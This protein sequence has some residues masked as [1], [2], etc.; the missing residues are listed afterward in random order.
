MAG[1][2]SRSL[3]R[4]RDF[5]IVCSSVGL[6]A[7]GDWVAIVGLGLH[8]EEM[9]GSGFAV[10]ALWICLFGPSVLVAGHAGLLVDRVEATRLLALVSAIGAVAAAV[11]AFVDATA[12]VLALTAALGVVFALMSPAEFSLV[13][14]LA[15]SR[16]QE[17]NGH[18]ETFRYIGFGLGPAVGGLLFA[19]G[20]LELTM[21][22]DAG[23]FAA[24]ALA[25]LALRIRRRP[26]DA[27]A[28]ES[29]RARDGIAFLFRD[30]VL[31]LVM[32]VAF[33]SLLFMSAVWVGE[34]FFVK[35]TLGMG[36]T[37]Y[38]LFMS[39]WTVGMA[40][41][42]LLLS[43]RVA[44]G[45]VAAAGLAA[46]AVQGLGLALPTLWLTFGFFLAC[47]F[48]GGVAH[49]VKNVMFRSLIHVRVPERMHG[50]AFAAYNGI[51][52]GA[53]LG[54]FA[55]GG[56][57]VAA[58]GPTGT[59]A[60]AGGLSAL[61]GLVGLLVLLRMNRGWVPTGPVGPPAGVPVSEGRTA[62]DD[63]SVVG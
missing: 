5:L 46:A 60:Y 39:V 6:S 12:A 54:A 33:T 37:A 35:D 4:N 51:R 19:A 10:A 25:A 63:A 61:A 23:T 55:A 1:R 41:G 28:E 15:G 13:P 7:M 26:D 3:L 48:V 9:T 57:L 42:A 62:S 29:P 50:R 14:P 36:D 47:A 58:I 8:V 18:V 24:V 31:A 38:G 34:I 44:A 27:A 32:V 43:R 17:A 40:L 56:V 16:I 52:N 30:R 20:G 59:L 2:S 53:E 49:G 11:L 21:L 45:A 22:V